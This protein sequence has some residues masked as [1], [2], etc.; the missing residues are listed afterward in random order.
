[1]LGK[2]QHIRPCANG[3]LH[4]GMKN[5][6]AEPEVETEHQTRWAHHLDDRR[7]VRKGMERLETNYDF[8]RAAGKDFKRTSWVIRSGIHH[9]GARKAGVELAEG[10]RPE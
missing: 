1:L 6:R 3:V 5:R 7:Q 10:R 8:A 4:R 2:T 9:E